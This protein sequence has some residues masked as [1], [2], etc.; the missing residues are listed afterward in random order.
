MRPR[1]AF[2]DW[3]Q[4]VA[5]FIPYTALI[6]TVRGVALGGQPLTAF[7]PELAIAGVWLALLLVAAT[8]AYRFVQ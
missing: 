1:A 5:H 7:G 2:P 3:L 6:A 4:G 8:R